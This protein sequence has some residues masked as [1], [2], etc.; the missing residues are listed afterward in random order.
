[1]TTNAQNTEAMAQRQSTA[2]PGPEEN[3]RTDDTT[4]TNSNGD[5]IM[6]RNKQKLKK[7]QPLKCCACGCATGPGQPIHM[8]HPH[9][10][11]PE[12]IDPRAPI[13]TPDMLLDMHDYRRKLGIDTAEFDQEFS[14][15]QPGD[16]AKICFLVTDHSFRWLP[17]KLRPSTDLLIESETM[18]VRVTD[19]E[20]QAP[21]AVYSAHLWGRPFLIDPEKLQI[22]S[23]VTFKA[24]HVHSFYP[25]GMPAN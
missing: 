3:T 24:R 16:L 8:H 17:K 5:S 14:H 15:I 6:A 7:A 1:M 21:N 4:T 23:R 19:V 2:K 9:P 10:V 11:E 25:G 20:G 12:A 13:A 18:W 22:G